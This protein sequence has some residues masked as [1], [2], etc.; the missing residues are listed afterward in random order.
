[1]PLP[2]RIR[3]LL[4]DLDGVLYV[5]DAAVP[6]AADA[7]CEIKRRGLPCRFTTNTTTKSVGALHQK[8]LAMGLPIERSELFTVIDAAKSHL[9]SMGNPACWFLLSD[10][11]LLDFSEFTKSSTAPDV[12][13]VGD[14]GKRWSY[15]LMN[16]VFNMMIKGARLVALHK[17]R[18]WQVEDGL[19]MDIGAF[20]AGLEYTTG[21]TATVIGKP[22]EEFFRLA[23]ADL[24]LGA[25]DVIMV[26]D[27]IHNDIAGAQRAGIACV[28]VRTGKYRRELV[29]QSGI[30]PDVVVRSIVDIPNLL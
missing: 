17:G 18:Y 27:D 22:S 26:G 16:T 24:R 9:R 12:I 14:I 19:R 15:G 3:G 7:L 5:G 2:A 1:M 28:L 4:F 8:L 21:Q 20:V 29:E 25:E 13:V 23:L 11:P 30:V 6:G 10:D